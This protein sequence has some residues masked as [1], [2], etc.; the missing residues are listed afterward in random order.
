MKS[1]PS[2]MMAFACE[3]VSSEPGKPIS[4]QH[5]LDGIEAADFPAPTARWLAVFCFYGDEETTVP[6]C[7][8]VIEHESGEMVAQAGVKDLRFTRNNPISRNVVGFSGFAWPYPG[9]YQVK[10]LVER[11]TVLARF[12]MLVQTAAPAAEADEDEGE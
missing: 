8:V 2:V 5:I 10:F 7:R 1:P 3:N 6:N 4:F 9:W 12:P 11:D